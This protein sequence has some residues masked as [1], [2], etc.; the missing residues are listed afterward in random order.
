M[1]A[2]EEAQRKL[3]AAST[4][5][6]F[7]VLFAP[8]A[9]RAALTA[10]LA[11]YVEI[12]ATLHQCSDAGVA[13]TKLGWWQEEIG[14]LAQRQPRHP[15][16]LQ[17]LAFLPASFTCI[18]LFQEIIESTSLDISPPAFQRFEDVQHYCQYRGGALLQLM[19]VLAGARQTDSLA[20][21]RDIG[22]AWELAEI[23]L[24]AGEQIHH[25]RVYFATEDLHRH[26][27]DRHSVAGTHTDSGLR[28]LLKD[29]AQRAQAFASNAFALPS[30][31]P[32]PLI[33]AR[34]VNGLAQARLQKF[35]ECGYHANAE[36]VELPALTRL[37]T[38]WRAARLAS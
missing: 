29:Y 37:L 38:A 4:D 7:A 17:L 34:V 10:L 9:Q 13:R 1:N 8:R 5:L 20:A 32:Q 3:A 27:L 33:A 14:L 28:T 23:V 15:L 6:R 19:A 24:H 22:T 31:E 35:A 25:G 21:A 16:A 18:S 36:P 30:T 11:I 2:I 12:R 26:S